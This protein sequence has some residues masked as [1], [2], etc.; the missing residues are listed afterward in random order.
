[1]RRLEPDWSISVIAPSSRPLLDRC[2]SIGVS[3]T[4]LPYPVPLSG[5]GEAAMAGSGRGTKGR[6]IR[7]GLKVAVTFPQYVRALRAALKR[8]GATVV[9]SNGLKAHVS[10]A[11][12]KPPGVRLVW[13]LH[14]YVQGRPITARLLR[15]LAYRADAIVANSESVLADA[16]A[17]LGPHSSIRRIYNAVDLCA[18]RPD[19]PALDLAALSG[20]TNDSGCARIGLVA[21]F[22]R[23]KGQDV[24]IEAIARL[25]TRRRIRAYVVGGPVYDTAGS[26]WSVDELRRQVAAR[27]LSNVVGFTGQ[28]D[29]VPGALRALDIMVHASTAP[30]PFGMVIAEGMASGLPVVA[31]RSGGAAELFDDGV[32]AVGHTAGD[33]TELARQLDELVSNSPRRAKV[34]AAAR[35]AACQRFAPERMAAEFREVY[36]G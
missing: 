11:L 19:G 20:L 25:Q 9:H 28:V 14:D 23:W 35:V 4:A 12:A 36:Q 3:A 13:Q 32:T 5:L 27:G 26:Q 30:E 18:F 31:T 6:L 8:H 33:A 24:F 1:L 34:G 22:A 7:E 2:R 17:A 21:T 15:R 10:A 29:D 16:T